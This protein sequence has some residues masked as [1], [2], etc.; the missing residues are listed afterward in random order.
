MNHPLA[1]ILTLK[2]SE[3]RLKRCQEHLASVGIT[4]KPFYGLDCEI[5]GLRTVHTY[6]L[7]HPGTNYVMGP[8]TV[9]LNLSHYMLW[10]MLAYQP[11]D[12]FWILEDDVKFDEDWEHRF[13]DA[14]SVLPADWDFV[15]L[16]S[17]CTSDKPQW[18]VGKNLN[19]VVYPMC[20]HAYMVRKKALPVMF[21]SC[22]KVYAPIDVELVTEVLHKLQQFTILPR[23]ASQFD[24][25]L[26][27]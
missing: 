14:K 25:L 5:T 12:E 3:A 4:A 2:R 21:T 17:C 11:E 24:T 18:N 22:Q 27:P 9:S 16:G 15:F 7:D 8:K 23:I 13:L 10:A 1:F 6:E 20:T 19:V 26:S